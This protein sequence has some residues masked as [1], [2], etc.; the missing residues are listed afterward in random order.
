MVLQSG[1]AADVDGVVTVRVVGF[2]LEGI[3]SLS[4]HVDEALLK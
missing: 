2:F 3:A 1:F 4:G